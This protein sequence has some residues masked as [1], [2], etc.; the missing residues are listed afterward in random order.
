M[1]VR[2]NIHTQ[3][4]EQTRAV[5]QYIGEYA[6]EGDIFLLSGELGTGKTCLTQGIAVGLG[7]PGYVRSPTFVLMTQYQGRLRLHHMDLYRLEGSF[8]AWDLGI[9]EQ[10]TS[11]DVCVIEWADRA[12]DIFPEESLWIDLTH[13]QNSDSRNITFYSQ[14]SKYESIITKLKQINFG[15]GRN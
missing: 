2:L 5:G 15:I 11:N 13:N 4:A 1:D 8:Q 3:S 9:E 7:V 14:S 6:Q 12:S 10:L